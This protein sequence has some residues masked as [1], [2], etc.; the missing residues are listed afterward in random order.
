MAKSKDNPGEEA[1]EMAGAAGMS[2]RKRMAG[3]ASGGN[4]GVRS[5]AEDHGGM[6][7]H[8][9]HKAH[10]GMKGHMEDGDRAAG[11]A[12]HHTRH[13]HPAQAAPMHGPHHVNGYGN[14]H[15]KR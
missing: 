6:G 3:A 11:P 9:D 13:H 15:N 2:P 10:T 14:H 5:Y 7:M 1:S 12:I 4:F 8:P